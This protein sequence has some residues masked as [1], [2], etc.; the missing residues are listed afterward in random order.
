MQRI[1]NNTTYEK[2]HDKTN[3][4]KTVHRNHIVPYYPKAEK[5]QELVENYVVPDDTD[6][7]YTHY[8]KHNIA[9]SIAHRGAQHIVI[10]QWPLVETQHTVNPSTILQPSFNVET[11][12][13]KDSGLESLQTQVDNTTH[14]QGTSSSNLLP[15]RIST[16]YPLQ[17]MYSPNSPQQENFST[18]PDNT[19]KFQATRKLFPQETHN[20]PI[21]SPYSS[22]PTASPNISNLPDTT[23][24][25]VNI[26][27]NETKQFDYNSIIHTKYYDISCFPLPFSPTNEALRYSSR[28]QPATTFSQISG[29]PDS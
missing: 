18:P 26:Y 7:Y 1:L 20:S 23:H 4:K 3:E 21:S 29:T 17:N 5:I 24:K 19:S 11:T 6:D 14:I 28:W 27:E 9:R 8:N 2:Q 25:K 12:P 13:T 22:T 16:P 10:S 15:P